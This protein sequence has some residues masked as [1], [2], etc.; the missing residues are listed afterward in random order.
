[1]P[2]LNANGVANANNTFS[3]KR[4]LADNQVCAS[5]LSKCHRID[6]KRVSGSTIIL[7]RFENG[8]QIES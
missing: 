1:M 3:Y 5:G 2:L 6:G 8:A 4:L 7:V